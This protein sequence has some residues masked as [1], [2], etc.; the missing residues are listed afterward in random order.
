MMGIV[1]ECRATCRSVI[2]DT[3]CQSTVNPRDRTFRCG[4]LV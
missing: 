1:E 2:F 3:R 4:L